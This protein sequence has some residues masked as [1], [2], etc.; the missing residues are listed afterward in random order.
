M[1]SWRH[2]E[3]EPPTGMSQASVP[4]PL[5]GVRLS[6]P[7]MCSGEG[8]PFGRAAVATRRGPSPTLTTSH[9]STD[10]A[11][12]SRGRVVN[13]PCISTKMRSNGPLRIAGAPLVATTRRPT[14]APPKPSYRFLCAAATGRALLD[15]KAP[16]DPRRLGLSPWIR[17]PHR[18]PGFSG[19]ARPDPAREANRSPSCS[20]D[21]DLSPAAGVAAA[22]DGCRVTA[23]APGLLRCGSGVGRW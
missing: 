5:A 6:R 10:L 7:V 13:L 4:A 21:G 9:L 8:A 2:P 18:A 16:G 19:R 1:R 22:T 12:L 17:H 11:K 15:V 23:S 3:A 14:I 20:E